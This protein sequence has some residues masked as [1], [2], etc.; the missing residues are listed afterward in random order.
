MSN[1]IEFYETS[2]NAARQFAA[3]A[4]AAYRDSKKDAQERKERQEFADRFRAKIEAKRA[5]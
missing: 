5:K 1:V 2:K 4:I 3:Q